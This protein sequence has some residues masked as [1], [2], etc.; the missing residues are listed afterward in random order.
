MSEHFE[1]P[2]RT[3]GPW[4]VNHFQYGRKRSIERNVWNAAKILNKFGIDGEPRYKLVRMAQY[5]REN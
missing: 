2:G 1:L 5:L 3:S 4:S